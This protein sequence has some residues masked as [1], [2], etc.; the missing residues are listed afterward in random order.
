MIFHKAYWFLTSEATPQTELTGI[1]SSSNHSIPSKCGALTSKTITGW[2]SRSFP[3]KR[4]VIELALEYRKDWTVTMVSNSFAVAVDSFLIYFSFISTVWVQKSTI[5]ALAFNLQFLN[6]RLCPELVVT[7]PPCIAGL[8]CAFF[9]LIFPI[10]FHFYWQEPS[11]NLSHS[12]SVTIQHFLTSP[13]G[14]KKSII[15]YQHKHQSKPRKRF[16]KPKRSL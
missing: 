5:M 2:P 15:Q 12:Q 11:L 7:A 8:D 4:A 3:L 10:E 1:M 6:V 13:M 14:P 16:F 9:Y